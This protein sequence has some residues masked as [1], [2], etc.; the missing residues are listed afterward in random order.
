MDL[1]A[2]N[3]EW[4]HTSW[5]AQESK[6]RVKNPEAKLAY[7]NQKEAAQKIFE[8]FRNTIVAVTLLALPQVGKTGVM[9]FV[10]YLMMTSS[11]AQK[12]SILFLE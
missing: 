2:R 5:I 7:D 1:Q 9:A 4:V 6:L 11:Y 3:R 12:I 8:C 10:A